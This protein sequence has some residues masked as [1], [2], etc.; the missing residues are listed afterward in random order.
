VPA[1]A[2]PADAVSSSSLV[3]QQI[4]VEVPAVWFDQANMLE[5]QHASVRQY[6]TS[7]RCDL[8]WQPERAAHESY[9]LKDSDAAPD[10]NQD[11][12]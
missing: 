5:E 2:V 8:V 9:R 6:R 10:H 11:H 1:D 7:T 3:I 4:M 12:K